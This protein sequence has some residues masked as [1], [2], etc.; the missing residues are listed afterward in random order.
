MKTQ[1]KVSGHRMDRSGME[2]HANTRNGCLVTRSKRV[3][4]GEGG[5]EVHSTSSKCK[6]KECYAQKEAKYTHQKKLNMGHTLCHVN[7][8]SLLPAVSCSKSEV[9][10]HVV[11]LRCVI[12]QPSLTGLVQMVWWQVQI[13][14]VARANRVVV[15]QVRA[16]CWQVQLACGKLAIDSTTS[17]KTLTGNPNK[18]RTA[19]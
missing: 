5:C 9:Q 4:Q 12:V 6:H 17:K 11:F 18:R 7:L 1:T 15:V 19:T 2:E 10:L 8:P 3:N 14:G 16:G 13:D